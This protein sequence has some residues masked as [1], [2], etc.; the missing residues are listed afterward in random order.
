M[1]FGNAQICKK[2]IFLSILAKKIF[3]IVPLKRIFNYSTPPGNWRKDSMKSKRP[4]AEDSFRSS[5]GE[6]LSE[7]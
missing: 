3:R 1:S 6:V 4:D 7:K 2:H 5:A